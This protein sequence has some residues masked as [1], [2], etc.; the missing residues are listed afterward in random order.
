MVQRSSRNKT[1]NM[2]QMLIGL[3]CVLAVLLVIAICVAVF[4]G[5]GQPEQP[6]DT[7]GGA[8]QT[9]AT[10]DTA[11]PIALTV[12][13]PTQQAFIT[14][15]EMLTFTGTAD[16][17]QSLSV[18]GQQVTCNSDG[19]FAYEVKLTP[20]VNEVI[21]SHK[22]ETV[23][24][25]VE[26]RYAVEKFSP[27]GDM[28]YSGGATIQLSISVRDG[29]KVKAELG[30]SKI[31]ME[32]SDNQVGSGVAEGF[33]LY[34]GTYRLPKNNTADQDMGK[35]TY[36]VTYDGVTE[37]YTSGSIVCK[38]SAEVLS[39]D[40]SVTP[41][42]GDYIDVGSG[43]IVE[44]ISYSAETFN[45]DTRDDY[46]DPRNNYLPEGTVDYASSKLVYDTSGNLAYRL[47]RCGRRV[48]VERRNYPATGK[49]AVVDCYQGTLPDHNEVGFASLEETGH[50]TVLTLDTLWKAPFYF[51]LAP[52]AY[53]DPDNRDFSIT[54]LTAEYVD[55]TFCYA[56]SFEGQVQIPSDN[57]L[58]RSATLTQNE[59]DCTLRLYLKNK[60][61]FYG[62]DSYYNDNGQLCFQFLNPVSATPASNAYGAD[63]SGIRIMIDVGHGG[64]DGGAVATTA[65]G[66]TI[67]EAECNLKLAQVLRAELESM[68]ATVIMNREDDASLTVDERI[69]FLKEQAPD[70]CI[71]I[72]QN[73]I[74]G[75]PNISGCEVMYFGPTSQK[76]AEEIRK[77]I[78]GSGVYSSTKIRWYLYYVS[79][80]T[81]SP[82]VLVECGYMTNARD[83]ANML[84]AD[85]LQ[86]KAES[87]AQGIANYFL[88]I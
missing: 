30:G 34:T 17:A 3:I 26:Y 1:K 65:T 84:D 46:S 44:I 73:S 18:N 7:S 53:A 59:S 33:V 60:G 38:K 25:T 37:V 80:E 35:I 87:M 6:A 36:T 76:A 88:K 9:D 52:Q 67:D 63:L 56:T 45:G 13:S 4:A 72:H 74:S 86:R 21:L 27:A 54:T 69:Q 83:L 32:K 19:T 75:Y 58:F 79:R 49:V 48:Y 81:V 29:S 57:P 23:R 55:I 11:A 31:D 68:G 82:V 78:A 50:Y 39:S 71:A 66:K 51:D 5:S 22:G 62:W 42:Y 77:E 43:Y 40:P 47:M 2:T 8:V 12:N 85:M 61:S 16:P 24:Y 28:E 20:G 14:V 41:D 70:L 64:L 10:G 15:E